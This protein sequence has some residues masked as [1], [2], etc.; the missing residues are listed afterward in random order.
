M[1]Q[2][3]TTRGIGAAFGVKMLVYGRAGIGKTRLCATAPEPIIFSAEAGLLSLAEFNLPF[4]QI[5]SM[6]DLFEAYQWAESSV[7]ARQFQTICLDSVSEIGEVIL[8]NARATGAGAKDPRNAYGELIERA[9][10]LIKKF[11]NLPGYNVYFSAK[12]ELMKTDTAGVNVFGPSMPGSK[13]GPA[14]PYLF[15]EVFA[16]NVQDQGEQSWTYLLTKANSLYE[17]KDR[18]GTL[19]PI[20]MPDLTHIINKITGLRPPFPGGKDSAPALT[21]GK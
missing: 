10:D 11:R 1:V 19:D 12:Q 13:L 7:E 16:L 4:V 2:I 9:L 18:S 3:L 5:S 14:L 20:E 6:A 15:D 17:A 8:A 21:T